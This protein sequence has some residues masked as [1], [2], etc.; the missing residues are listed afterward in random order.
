MVK[1]GKSSA[2][3]VWLNAFHFYDLC[4][5]EDVCEF[6]RAALLFLVLD[7]VQNSFLDRVSL[8]YGFVVVVSLVSVLVSA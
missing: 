5:R 8:G 7:D 2:L 3:L 4:P 6:D 1:A